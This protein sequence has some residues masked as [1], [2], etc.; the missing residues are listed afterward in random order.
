MTRGLI[1]DYG[2][3]KL[4]YIDGE[5]NIVKT[6]VLPYKPIGC[7][8]MDNMLIVSDW[9]NSALR[10]YND[11]DVL[12]KT[13]N[14]SYRPY[15]LEC[16]NGCLV[17]GHES[18]TL[19][20]FYDGEGVEIKEWAGVGWLDAIGYINNMIYQGDGQ[21]GDVIRMDIEGKIIGSSRYGYLLRG[22]SGCNGN[23]S[24]GDKPNN[25]LSHYNIE[26]VEIDRW[27]YPFQ[28]YGIAYTED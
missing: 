6:T 25:K 24:V 9:T 11:E 4:H 22:I 26:D 5:S 23:Y 16:I 27:Y 8:Y 18:A 17:I 21:Y 13:V 10:Y 1:T 2:Y 12:V 7:V 14:L 3:S 28:V 20:H 15:D 19:M